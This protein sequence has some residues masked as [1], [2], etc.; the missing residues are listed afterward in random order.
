MS[1]STL[2]VPSHS[3]ESALNYQNFNYHVNSN[4]KNRI[5]AMQSLDEIIE[6]VHNNL[7]TMSKEEKLSTLKRVITDDLLDNILLTYSF[8]NLDFAPL[9]SVTI[10][11]FIQLA[12]SILVRYHPKAG[13]EYFDDNTWTLYTSK[14]T[15]PNEY[16]LEEGECIFENTISYAHYTCDTTLNFLKNLI[17]VLNQIADNIIVREKKIY[18]KSEYAIIVHIHAIDKNIISPKSIK[19]GKINKY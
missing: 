16:I 6:T 12:S 15:E 1:S 11:T 19:A 7:S 14:N 10:D 4:L 9:K 5:A 8:N 2:Q 18:V 13:G 17:R 3:H